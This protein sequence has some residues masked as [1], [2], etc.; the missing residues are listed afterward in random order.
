MAGPLLGRK[1]VL[2]V[3]AETT[4]GTAE[5]LTAGEA[6][7]IAYDVTV[8]PNI[9]MLRRP[10]QGGFG[11]H[12]AVAGP[13]RG[14]AS[15]RIDLGGSGN[16]ASPVPGWADAL[17][18]G[19]GVV[20]TAAVTTN[21]SAATAA[22]P[23]VLT[24]ASVS[25]IAAGDWVYVA[26]ISGNMGTDVLNGRMHRVTAVKVGDS[27]ITIAAN[28]TGKT[29]T[30]GGTVGRAAYFAPSSLPPEAGGSAT[31]TLTIGRWSDGRL[32]TIHGA[33]GSLR[34]SGPTGRIVAAEFT[35][36][37]IY[38]RP[39]DAALVVP[40]WPTVVPPKFAGRLEVGGAALK[41]A[42]LTIDLGNEVV[43]REDA[44]SSTGFCSAVVVDRLVVGSM[45]PEAGL[46]AD[47]PQVADW[48]DGESDTFFAQ[49]GSTLGNIVAIAAPACQRT[50]VQTGE[51]NKLAVDQIDVQFNPSADAGNDEIRIYFL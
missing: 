37:G 49:V 14:Q 18:P 7:M 30:S 35:F 50:N 24:V 42:S 8:S 31:K 43:L 38:D 34:L 39:A 51:R 4:V 36:T 2:G 16:S 10:R 25:G 13:P 26:D 3:K 44:N 27:K 29:Y 32:T 12:S 19:C 1:T 9:E 22:N 47:L 15:F 5:S 33:M 6:A 28:T 23:C 17:L 45:D 46:V 11:E 20:K 41:I 40:T 48:L 21:I